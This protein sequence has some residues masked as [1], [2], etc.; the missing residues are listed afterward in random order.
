MLAHAGWLW[1]L[2]QAPK[3]TLQAQNLQRQ[4]QRGEVG[5]QHFLKVS[6]CQ[7]C[8]SGTVRHSLPEVS[9]LQLTVTP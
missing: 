8:I 3:A 4:E 5:G 7:N 1:N 2:R 9:Y 6:V